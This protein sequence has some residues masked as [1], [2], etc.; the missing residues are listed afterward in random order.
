MFYAVIQWIYDLN[1]ANII[2]L[3]QQNLSQWPPLFD[4][5]WRATSISDLWGLRWHQLFRSSF[6]QLGAKPL[7]AFIGRTGILGAFFV[8]AIL[9]DWGMWAM[10]RGSYFSSVG[11]FFGMMGVGC[12]LE[13]LFEKML[14]MKVQGWWGWLWTMMWIVGW[15]TGSLTLG[16]G[17]A[18]WGA[19]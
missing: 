7:S 6:V 12:I 9:H 8:S 15:G 18:F 13:D 17:Q 2:L 19:Q 16:L 5:P 4:A 10:G 1:T 11:R 14:S 3:F